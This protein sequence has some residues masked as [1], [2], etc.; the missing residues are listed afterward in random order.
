MQFPV[1]HDARGP[2]ARAGAGLEGHAPGAVTA[3]GVPVRLSGHQGGGR[4]AHGPA[5]RAR[6]GVRMVLGIVCMAWACP[7]CNRSSMIAQI[8]LPRPVKRVVQFGE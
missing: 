3:Q 6:S 2:A 1:A 7:R 8:A 5:C 4:L